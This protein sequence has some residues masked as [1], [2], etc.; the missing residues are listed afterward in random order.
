MVENHTRYPQPANQAPA[1][2]PEINRSA[3]AIPATKAAR[4]RAPKDR[5]KAFNQAKAN[6]IGCVRNWIQIRTVSRKQTQ[7]APSR[8]NQLTHL[9]P[10]VCAQTIHSCSQDSTLRAV[11][12][13][14][15]LP[16]SQRRHEQ[17]LHEC[18]EYI[19][20]DRTINHHVRLNPI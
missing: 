19:A 9:R 8:F 6:S 12:A 13:N 17:M 15:H 5:K 4:D 11:R 16:R 7:L 2:T 18:H 10:F 3:R 14:H 20:I 1:S